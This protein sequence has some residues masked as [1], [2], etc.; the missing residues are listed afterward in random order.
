[1]AFH[2][3]FPA[4]Q[5]VFPNLDRRDENA[6]RQRQT[7]PGIL[8]GSQPSSYQRYSYENYQPRTTAT[9]STAS[10]NA[11][12][13]QTERG[14]PSNQ[15]HLAP[16]RRHV[17]TPDPVA[18]RYL[19]EDPC[20][21][22]VNRRATLEGYE[23]YLV[24][25]WVCSRQ[26]PTIVI[27]TYTGDSH[28]A[29]VVGVLAVPA[30]ESDWSARL[31]IYFRTMEKFHARP[32]ESPLGEIMVT[33]LSSF[34][35][36]LTVI[37]VRDGDIRQHRQDFIVNEDLKRLGCSGRSGLTLSEPS[38]AT[39]EKFQ[40]LYKTSDHI[41]FTESVIELIKQCQTALSIFEMLDQQ[42][43]D[44]L[45]CD[46]TETAVGDWWTKIGAEYYNA[47]PTDGIL[48]PTTIAAL[49]G[50]LM[51][52]RNRLAW[53]GVSV[54]K[55]VFDI[56]AMKKAIGSFQKDVK[57]E[58]TRRLDHHTL[59][60][61]H[62]VTTKAA[63][64]DG[65]WGVQKAIKSTV[66]GFGGK[67]GE[68]VYGMVGGKDRGNIGDIETLDI[69]KFVGLIYGE[70]PKWLWAGKPMRAPTSSATGVL[71]NV[72]GDHFQDRSI[73][74]AVDLT[75]GFITGSTS[76]EKEREKEKLKNQPV[77]STTTAASGHPG[78]GNSDQHTHP[79]S[80]EANGAAQGIAQASTPMAADPM[81][82]SGGPVSAAYTES[83]DMASQGKSGKAPFYAALPTGSATSVNESPYDREREK[84][85]YRDSDRDRKRT[86]FQSVAGRVSDARSGLGRIRDA[87]GGGLR[88]H[89]S[90]TLR[91]DTG[92]GPNSA[93]TSFGPDHVSSV[94]SSS[95]LSGAPMTAPYGIA[96]PAQ[97]SLSSPVM[98]GRAFTWKTKPEEYLNSLRHERELRQSLPMSENQS[99][100]E[101]IPSGSHHPDDTDDGE[102]AAAALEAEL[103]LRLPGYSIPANGRARHLHKEMAAIATDTDATV[104][105]SVA[106]ESDVDGPVN[107]AERDYGPGVL[108]LLRRH[109]IAGHEYA[110]DHAS[111]NFLP[112][113]DDSIE[114]LPQ[115]G[116]PYQQHRLPFEAAGL[117][118]LSFSVAEEAILDWG[119]IID[120][121]DVELDAA[122]EEGE[123]TGNDEESGD[124]IDDK[125]VRN[126]SE[127]DL[128]DQIALLAA[129]ARFATALAVER[130][131]Y[132]DVSKLKDVVG[133]VVHDRINALE[134]L[135]A[136]Y[137]SQIQEVQDIFF[138]LSSAYERVQSNS[139]DLLGQE[140]VQTTEAVHEVETLMAKVEYEIGSLASKVQ[141]VEE[142]VRQFTQQVEYLEQRADELQSHLETE[143]WLHWLVRSVTG[144]GT[145]PDVVEGGG[146][147]PERRPPR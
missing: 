53:F 69:D 67:R 72:M 18:F 81:T 74:A 140:R 108:G 34:P 11:N 96:S 12:P 3:G 43:I 103:S 36:A 59:R 55:D 8:D 110:L 4:T 26:S 122:D 82:A 111:Y 63:A 62:S 40:S 56:D 44:G 77:T 120:L 68:L 87:M 112:E 90:R 84:R 115:K 116:G 38:R 79:W 114:R 132:E 32:K 37:A 88:N 95:A 70:R 135:D 41:P 123:K 99:A 17:V 22:V 94:Q 39:Q 104:A 125:G 89:A 136:V 9:S 126:G 100:A 33:N 142:G 76:K 60:R 80:M 73:A 20:V 47:E 14:T 28:Q 98:M 31:R 52:A 127:D 105:A 147:R 10:T 92:P 58:R 121:A 144:I 23:L 7:R 129:S 143:S 16:N 106:K 66:E 128:S 42:Y 97:A 139:Q 131:L 13:L 25:Q 6:R 134:S 118:R 61:L 109:S 124:E 30:N 130:G 57:L 91:D 46:V 15:P 145:V 83:T 49:L 93:A 2:A 35:S 21:S 102:A 101:I 19:E 50:M 86:M 117:R 146:G 54:S 113:G 48:G 75:S 107:E 85:Q 64:G 137:T 78:Q 5:L 45:L 51:G 27:A 29:V 141:D 133:P 1:M 119:D 24:E 65:G 138:Q 71:P